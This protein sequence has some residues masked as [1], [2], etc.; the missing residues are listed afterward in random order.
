MFGFYKWH[1]G[2]TKFRTV[3]ELQ[4]LVVSVVLDSQCDTFPNISSD[5]SCEYP[6]NVNVS[7]SK[8]SVTDL[9]AKG[10]LHAMSYCEFLASEFIIPISKVTIKA[11][12]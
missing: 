1:R 11:W 8:L 6:G 7:F 3:T 12:W 5:E 10:S 2:S 4:Q 9:S